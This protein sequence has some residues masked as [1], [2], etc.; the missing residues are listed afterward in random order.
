M[1][2]S[3]LFQSRSW[4]SQLPYV[5]GSDS[6]FLCDLDGIT[7]LNYFVDVAFCSPLFIQSESRSL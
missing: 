2:E 4:S 1:L 3:P 5:T 7:V 6:E